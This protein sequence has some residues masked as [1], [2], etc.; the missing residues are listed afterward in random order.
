MAKDEQE[1]ELTPELTKALAEA[2]DIDTKVGDSVEAAVK[3]ALENASE[4]VATKV[5]AAIEKTTKKDVGTEDEDEE[6]ADD[7]EKSASK[8]KYGKTGLEKLD[9]KA[10]FAKQALAFYNGEAGELAKFNQETLNRREKAGYANEGT[11]ADGG[12]LVPDPEFDTTIYENLPRYGVVFKYGTTRQTDRNQIYDLSLSS[13]LSF[14]EI[15][16]AGATEAGVIPSGKL[17]IARGLKQLRKFGVFVP[18]TEELDEDSIVDFWNIV[19]QSLSRGYAKKADELT[20][21]DAASGITNLSGV[22]TQAVSG[23]GTTI[24]WDDLLKSEAKL[25]DDLDVSNHKWFMRKETYFRLAQTKTTGSGE[26]LWDG[27]KTDPKNPSTPWGTQIVFTRVLPQSTTVNAN[28]GFAVYGDLSNYSLVTKRG[29]R[30]EMFNQA[31]IKD[32]SNSDF[33]LATQD[34]KAM[35]AIIRMLGRCPT[36]VQ[37]KFV[38][39]GTGT[40]SQIDGIT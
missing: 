12:Y 26:Y 23:A 35:R 18:A 13:D 25:E 33:N 11:S 5:L 4:E 31:I 8:L 38:V 9:A 28:D 10:L 2:L 1:I 34:A 39:L 24:T 7:A 15:G 22:L 36:G 20:F 3:T 17:V 19:T 29:M 27:F 21:M 40:V 16:T 32:T 37:S 6:N 14:T 30:M